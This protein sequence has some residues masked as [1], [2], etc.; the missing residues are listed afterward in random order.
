MATVCS[1][2][3]SPAWRLNV[4]GSAGRGVGV[5]VGTG[6][7]VVEGVGVAVAVGWGPWAPVGV[8]ATVAVG[9]GVEVG[10]CGTG[11]QAAAIDPARTALSRQIGK[12]GLGKPIASQPIEGNRQQ[13][14]G[15]V[16]AFGT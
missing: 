13:A 15:L 1:P 3:C 8:A 11:A 16:A 7:A 6:G 14:Y 4:G 2:M 9:C 10:D 12:R 5:G